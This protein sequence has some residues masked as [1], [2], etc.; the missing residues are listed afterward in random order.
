[1][2]GYSPIPIL[3]HKATTKQN[4]INH[5]VESG[6]SFVLS[7]PSAA[8]KACQSGTFAVCPELPAEN[9]NYVNDAL[10][11]LGIVFFALQALASSGFLGWMAYFRNAAVVKASQPEFLSLVAIGCVMLASAIL[12]LSIQG[13]YRFERDALTLE[14]GEIVNEDIYRVDAACMVSCN[15]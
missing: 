4:F 2:Q 14:E 11:I 10:I 13:G 15:L 8:E 1:M 5:A 9:Y 7:P 12:P 6:P 3:T